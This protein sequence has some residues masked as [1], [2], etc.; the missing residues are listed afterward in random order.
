M[1]QIRHVG[2]DR[3]EVIRKAKEARFSD[4]KMY[5]LYQ[6]SSVKEV[7]LCFLNF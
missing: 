4:E 2:I 7:I 5:K 3:N 6:L 1:N